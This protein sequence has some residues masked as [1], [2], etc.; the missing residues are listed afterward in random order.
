MANVIPYNQAEKKQMGASFLIAV[1]LKS[2]ASSAV[3]CQ[4]STTMTLSH[5]LTHPQIATGHES[6]VPLESCASKSE[7]LT[8]TLFLK[9]RGGGGAGG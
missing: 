6:N 2:S 9:K 7:T 1:D 3:C 5:V 8:E 4:Y